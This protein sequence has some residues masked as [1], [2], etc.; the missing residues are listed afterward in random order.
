MSTQKMICLLSVKAFRGRHVKFL[1]RKLIFKQSIQGWY[2]QMI[3]IDIS[4][5][6]CIIS[7]T[8]K[9]YYSLFGRLGDD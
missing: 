3:F 2:F 8:G 6:M 1:F 7:P 9:V 4:D 5:Q